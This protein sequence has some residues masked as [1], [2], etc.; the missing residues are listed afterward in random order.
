MSCYH[1]YIPITVLPSRMDTYHAALPQA[2]LTTLKL[3][4]ITHKISIATA[5]QVDKSHCYIAFAFS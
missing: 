1:L 4:E 3:A 2:C 5:G